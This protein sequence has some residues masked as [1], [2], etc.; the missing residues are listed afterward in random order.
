[1]LTVVA[2]EVLA[3]RFGDEPARVLALHGWGRTGA[4]FARVLE[5]TDGLAVHL[6]GFGHTPAPPEPWGSADYAAHL[7]RAIDDSRVE[8][9]PYVVVGH[10]FG[11]RVAVRLAAQR[12]DLVSALVLTGVP[13]VRAMPPPRPR[14]TLRVAKKLNAARLLPESVVDR[15]RRSGGSADYNAAQ[16]VMRGVLVRVVGE[17]Y[18]EDLARITTP[19]HMVWGELDDAASPAGARMAADLLADVRLDVVP[20]AGH[21]I[22]GDLERALREKLRDVSGTSAGT[23][24]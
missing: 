10:S 22:E 11:G 23:A 9:G 2:G 8:R 18:R 14:L 6:P 7:S 5:G 4:D 20:G 21:L 16:G 13:L 1:M 24:R 3:D 15:L 17:D 12:P 19:V